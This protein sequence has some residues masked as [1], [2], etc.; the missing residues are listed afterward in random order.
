MILEGVETEAVEDIG[1]GKV[2]ILT[3][4]ARV[5][6]K[7][8]QVDQTKFVQAARR[9][10]SLTQAEVSRFKAETKED[11]VKVMEK[12]RVNLFAKEAEAYDASEEAGEEAASSGC[13]EK[14]NCLQ[15]HGLAWRMQRWRQVQVRS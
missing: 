12:K 3:G 7:S 5:A 15:E 8:Q 6:K 1:G 4:D 2:R 9:Y 10:R 14:E 13:E 11:E